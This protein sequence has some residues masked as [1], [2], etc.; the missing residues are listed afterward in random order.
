MIDEL[1]ELVCKRPFKPF[2]IVMRDGRELFVTRVAQVGIG[3]T[4]FGYA[5]DSARKTLHLGIDQIASLETLGA[6]KA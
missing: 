6:V 2:R 3:L 1:K 4:K 5:D